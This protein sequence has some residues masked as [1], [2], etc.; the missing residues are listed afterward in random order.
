MKFELPNLDYSKNAL[1]P[2]MSE[3]TLVISETIKKSILKIKN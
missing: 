3:E 1:S 2:I